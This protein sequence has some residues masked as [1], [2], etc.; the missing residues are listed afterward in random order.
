LSKTKKGFLIQKSDEIGAIQKV[1]NRLAEKNISVI[2]AAAVAAWKGRYG[3]IM[4]ANP[5]NYRRVAR[6][7]NAK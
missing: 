4:W 3:M 2:S 1:M 6:V 5:K 7:L